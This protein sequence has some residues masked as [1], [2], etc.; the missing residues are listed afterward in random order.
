[1]MASTTIRGARLHYRVE[2]EGD[3]LL[4]I[5]GYPLAGQLWDEAVG[6]LR[7]DHRCIVPDLRGHGASEAT[8]RVTIADYADD[9]IGILD[10]I[11][12]G[13][14]VTLIGL[15]MGG[16]VAFDFVRRYGERVAALALVDTRAAADS[17]DAAAGRRETA[18]RVLREGSGFVA[19]EMATKL[20]ASGADAP[21]RE[22]WRQIMAATPPLGVA[23]ALHAIAER[24]DSYPVLE[25]L[26]VPVL[27]VVG[28]ED[29]ITPPDE[30]RRMQALLP[31]AV[32]EIIPGAGHLPPVEQ[33]EA[34]TAALRRFLR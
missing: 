18:E 19:A 16:Y 25:A 17:A 1:M 6:E 15:S 31:S 21:L 27:I 12:E 3:P 8:E 32:L 4:F 28:A 2:G 34:F 5:H 7:A 11:G 9:L 22:E 13:G 29:S 23:A 20:F 33:P 30:A 10:E 24:P 26:K 14:P